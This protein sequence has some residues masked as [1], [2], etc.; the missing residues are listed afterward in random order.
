MKKLLFLLTFVLCLTKIYAQD[1]Y[2]SSPT[3]EVE[4]NYITKGYQIQIESGLDM[5]K[6]YSIGDMS[7]KTIGDYTFTIN[8]LIRTDKKEIAALMIITK[9]KLSGKTYYFCIP[10]GNEELKKKYQ[11]D[12]Y[13]WD[14][15][16]MKAYT[17]FISTEFSEIVTI[18]YNLEKALKK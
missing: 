13:S 14:Y 16:I 5:K 8:C 6:G 18:A 3:T 10:H 11:Q 15:S 17:F 1:E 7:Q 4:Y 12:L 2:S 9:S